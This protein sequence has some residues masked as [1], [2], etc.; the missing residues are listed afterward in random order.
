VT[1][2]VPGYGAVVPL[3]DAPEPPVKGTKVVFDVTS[4]GADASAPLPGLLRVATL[5]NLAGTAGLKP[6]DVE[7]V[8]VLHGDATASALTDDAYRTATGRAHPSADLIT[9]L[10]AVGVKF[11]VCGQA[12]A[13]KGFDPKLVRPKVSVAASAVSATIN[14]QARGY[15]FIPAH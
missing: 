14:L 11:L 6:A 8:V 12:L 9:K 10:Q 1:P 5:L 7:V 13:R 4:T 15:A 3:P 2:V